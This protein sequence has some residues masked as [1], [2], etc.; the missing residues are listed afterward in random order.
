MIGL[1]R[2]L[3]FDDP[4]SGEVPDAHKPYHGQIVFVV[5]LAERGDDD[6]L[7]ISSDPNVFLVRASDGFEFIAFDTELL[8]STSQGVGGDRRNLH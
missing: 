3:H 8:E 4:R 2:H 1:M 5:R 6:F 7:L